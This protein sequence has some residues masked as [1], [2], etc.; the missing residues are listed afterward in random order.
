[1]RKLI[2]RNLK[3]GREYPVDDTGWAKLQETGHAAKFTIVEEH[4]VR[5][6]SAKRSY[7]PEEIRLELGLPGIEEA[8]KKEEQPAPL[9]GQQRDHAQNG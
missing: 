5:T 3:T 7:L 2:I 4:V 6:E 1:M 9:R 8:K